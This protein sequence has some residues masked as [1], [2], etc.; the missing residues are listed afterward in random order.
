LRADSAYQSQVKEQWLALN[1]SPQQA[2]TLNTDKVIYKVKP[3]D[4]LAKIA[5]KHDV[6]VAELKQ[7]NKKTIKGS[8]V[9][10]GQRLTIYPNRA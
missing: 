5:K 3:G 2:S 7:W 6:S 1:N 9:N 10:K 4:N 8:K